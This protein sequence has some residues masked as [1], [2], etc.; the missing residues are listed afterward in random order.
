MAQGNKSRGDEFDNVVVAVE[1]EENFS[2][3]PGVQGYYKPPRREPVYHHSYNY[4]NSNDDWCF[5]TDTKVQL[6]DGRKVAMKDL[7]PGDSVQVV[8]KNGQIVYSP[9][10][11]MLHYEPDENATFLQIYIDGKNEPFSLTTNHL[12]YA[13]K[14][15]Q[16]I[17]ESPIL[18]ENV[19]EGMFVFVADEDSGKVAP[20]KVREVLEVEA[21]GYCAPLTEEGTILADGGS[22]F[23][24]C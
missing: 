6:C 9:Y 18:A 15:P 3:G 19:E 5:P 24:L 16:E 17:L 4:H 22:G 12:L 14:K 21:T 7:K 2:V 10:L 1:S 13:T 23:V 11:A 8:K 20:A